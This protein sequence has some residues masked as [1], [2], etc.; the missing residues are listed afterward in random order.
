MKLIPFF[1]FA[2]I[3]PF[4]WYEASAEDWS[5]FR[6]GLAMSVSAGEPLKAS[7]NGASV[8]WK[9]QLPGTGWSQPVVVGNKVFVT[10]E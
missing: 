4:V 9:T 6:G 8:A 5:Q 3:V 10:T 1:G 2:A 7:P